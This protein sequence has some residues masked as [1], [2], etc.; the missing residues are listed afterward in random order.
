M[1]PPIFIT[2][3]IVGAEL[4]RKDTPFLP[5]TPEEIAEEARRVREAGAAIIHL[6]VRDKKGRPTQDIKIFKAAIDAIEDKCADIGPPIIQISTGGAVGTPLKERLKPLELRP[7]M[8]SLTTGT[9]N[10]GAAVFMNDLKTIETIAKR[11]KELG[12]K[13]EIEIFD[14]GM[15]STATG[16]LKKGLIDAPLH[17]NFVLGVPGGMPGG[18]EDLI[19]L[20]KKLPKGSTWSVSGIG[21]MQLPLSLAAIILN[22][23]VRV[24]LEDN[25]YFSKGVLGEGTAPFVRRIANYARELDRDV[26]DVGQTKRILKL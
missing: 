9:L 26:A 10:F 7:D 20:I 24:G 6:H 18:L 21:R 1:K 8:A 25:I 19:Y 2:A 14:S 12:I 11:L 15:I 3:A 4:T 5:L 16:L 22:G 23:H 13:P 17:F